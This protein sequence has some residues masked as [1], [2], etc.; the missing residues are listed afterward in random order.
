MLSF[1]IRDLRE[2]IGSYKAEAGL[3]RITRNG[4]TVIYDILI[5]YVGRIKLAS[6][7]V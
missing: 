6:N 1:G 2:Q 7:Q 4:R 5:R 3:Q